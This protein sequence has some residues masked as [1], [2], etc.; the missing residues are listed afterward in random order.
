[1]Y[2]VLV[3]GKGADG[4]VYGVDLAK[5]RRP[6]GEFAD[7]AWARAGELAD[8]DMR[9]AAEAL[10]PGTLAVLIVYEN[11][12]AIPFVAA[13][14]DVPGAS[15]SAVPGARKTCSGREKKTSRWKCPPEDIVLCQDCC[16]SRPE[17]PWSPEPRPR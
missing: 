3:V 13:A 12:W 9:Q 7:L 1:M 8:D 16:R 10:Q 2:D 4:T 6:L 5:L 17:P 15:W 11:T 14:R